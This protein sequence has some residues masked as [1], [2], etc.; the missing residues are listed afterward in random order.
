MKCN[1]AVVPTCD[2]DKPIFTQEIPDTQEPDPSSELE[3]LIE[4]LAQN[5]TPVPLP[6]PDSPQVP[7]PPK[8]VQTVEVVESQAALPSGPGAGGEST[9]HD[10]P[11]HVS[12]QWP[13]ADEDCLT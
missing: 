1:E 7:S 9:D 8:S 3:A 4:N 13:K 5:L 2:M 10:A 12:L 6:G 11:P